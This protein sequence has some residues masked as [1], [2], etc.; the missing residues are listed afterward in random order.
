MTRGKRTKDKEERILQAAVRL[1]GR[2]G[3][4]ASSIADIADEAGVAA[5]TIY[6]YFKRK[7]DLLV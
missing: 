7:E 3:Y 1:F 5:G 6:L 4:H 2:K